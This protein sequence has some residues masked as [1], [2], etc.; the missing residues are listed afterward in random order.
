M[1]VIQIIVR[2]L[3][4]IPENKEKKEG[5]LDNC[6]DWLE[7]SKESLSVQ[8]LIDIQISRESHKP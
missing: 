8:R 4:T 6:R 2:A 1:T 3:G 5:E 7:Y